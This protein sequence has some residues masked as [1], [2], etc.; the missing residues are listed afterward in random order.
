MLDLLKRDV[1]SSRSALRQWT[2][3][4]ATLSDWFLQPH[5]LHL[6]ADVVEPY[7]IGVAKVIALLFLAI[8]LYGGCMAH[9]E[10][11][12]PCDYI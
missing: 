1:T 11:K 6:Y 4:A 12:E 5:R 7:L 2:E 8:K 3:A 10:P 9:L